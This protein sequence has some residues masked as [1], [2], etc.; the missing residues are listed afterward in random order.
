M[1]GS[2]AIKAAIFATGALVGGGAAAFIT[3]RHQLRPLPSASNSSA[4]IVSSDGAGNVTL[5]DAGITPSSILK[6]GH[7]GQYTEQTPSCF[8]LLFCYQVQSQIR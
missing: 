5:A 7:P 6:Y 2:A 8:V 3:S 1:S 4:P